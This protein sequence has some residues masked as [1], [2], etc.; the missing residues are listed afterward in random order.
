MNNYPKIMGA[1]LFHPYRCH[2]CKRKMNFHDGMK[3]DK[4]RNVMIHKACEGK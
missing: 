4:E 1:W 2:V 3:V